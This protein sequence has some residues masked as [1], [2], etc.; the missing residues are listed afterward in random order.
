MERHTP[1]T[2]NVQ[3]SVAHP[4]LQNGEIS[5]AIWAMFMEYQQQHRAGTIALLRDVTV[6][7]VEL[8]TASDRDWIMQEDISDDDIEEKQKQ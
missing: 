1:L 8:R 7:L 2:F 3:L 4:S 5:T 6:L